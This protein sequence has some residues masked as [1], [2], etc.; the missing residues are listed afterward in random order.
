MKLKTQ[1]NSAI[2]DEL[3][4]LKRRLKDM[5]QTVVRIAKETHTETI[6][7][8]VEQTEITKASPFIKQGDEHGL[9]DKIEVNVTNT[10][11]GV[12]VVIGVPEG[13]P[14]T[15][16]YVQEHGAA[17]PVTP[18]MRGYIAYTWGIYLKQSTTHIHVPGKQFWSKSMM[19]GSAKIR[20]A[21]ALK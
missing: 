20:A 21:L 15:I 18:K 10:S 4:R 9:S 13:E 1:V 14:T 19:A 3:D 6:A 17:I 7:R 2:L 8:L 11:Q 16:A 5:E 12:K